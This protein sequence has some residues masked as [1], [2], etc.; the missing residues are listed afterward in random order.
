MGYSDNFDLHR[1]CNIDELVFVVKSAYFNGSHDNLECL[2]IH[3]PTLDDHWQ[4]HNTGIKRQ[5]PKLSIHYIRAPP[6]SNSNFTSSSNTSTSGVPIGAVVGGVIG[7]VVLGLVLAMALYLFCRGRDR[8][9][10]NSPGTEGAPE[11]E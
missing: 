8:G 7:G 5:P 10:S 4:W 6:A 2:Y 3:V 1:R 11:K 9:N